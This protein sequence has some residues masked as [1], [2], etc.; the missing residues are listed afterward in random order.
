MLF[1][2]IHLKTHILLT[3]IS[4]CLCVIA[5]REA[6][7]RNC[8]GLVARVGHDLATNPPPVLQQTERHSQERVVNSAPY[9]ATCPSST[10]L[11]QESSWTEPVLLL[12]PCSGLED[13][14]PHWFSKCGSQPATWVIWEVI[15][16]ANIHGPTSEPVKLWRLSPAIYGLTSPPG[17]SNA[18]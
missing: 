14:P 10:A 7:P 4:S 12:L 17:D 16:N 15:R 5:R 13:K 6:Q 9:P 3:D 8:G 2:E 18:H 1:R 11:T